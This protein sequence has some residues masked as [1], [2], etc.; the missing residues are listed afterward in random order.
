MD[1]KELYAKREK[2]SKAT[3][4]RALR[5]MAQDAEIDECR[6]CSYSAVSYLS[7][8]DETSI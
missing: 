8:I 3:I 4:M 2:M 6:T 1:T 5:N 7:N